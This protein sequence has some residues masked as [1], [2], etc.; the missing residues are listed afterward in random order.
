M[1]E[2]VLLTASGSPPIGFAYNST[3]VS[4]IN[5][6]SVTGHC[7]D[8]WQLLGV[9]TCNHPE[10]SVLFDG[11]IPTLTGLD[12]DSWAD[13]LLTL[14]TSN[15]ALLEEKDTHIQLTFPSVQSRLRLE[16]VLFNCPE[17]Q[18]E[19][20]FTPHNYFIKITLGPRTLTP[21]SHPATH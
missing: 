3:L 17:S 10:T 20:P 8:A 12:G 2:N 16:V 13:Q 1:I 21:P 14:N 15:M 5:G 18:A 19:S 4:P 9:V 11:N 7:E 6:S